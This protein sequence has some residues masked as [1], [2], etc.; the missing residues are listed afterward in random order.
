[1]TT[2]ATS[3]R[4]ARIICQLRQGGFAEVASLGNCKLARGDIRQ[5]RQFRGL[6]LPTGGQKLVELAGIGK[7][8]HVRWR[9]GRNEIAHDWAALGAQ[10]REHPWKNRCYLLDALLTR[11]AGLEA[12]QT[13]VNSLKGLLRVSSVAVKCG[14]VRSMFQRINLPIQKLIA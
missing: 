6:V 12:E 11:E 9:T 10:H 3:W 7:S 4:F 5:V 8:A 14:A 1:M 13:A 2:N